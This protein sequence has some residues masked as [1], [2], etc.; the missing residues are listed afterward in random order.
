MTPTLADVRA[1]YD[2][3]LLD[4]VHRAATVHRA[5][6]DASEVQLCALQSIKTGGCGE[7]C[8]Y[9]AQSRHH[10]T[11]V[12]PE[13]LMDTE[14]VLAK[15]RAAKAAGSTRFCMGA[16]WRG[17]AGPRAFDRILD[18]VRGV[19]A[20][21]LEACMTLGQLTA[22]QARALA[23]AGLSAY[24]HNL[25]TSEAHY[26]KV[27]TTRTYADRLQT[28]GHVADAGISLCC[29]GILGL[30]EGADDRIALLHRLATLDP[31]PESVPINRLVPVPGT[32]LEGAAPLDVFAWVRCVAVARVLLPRSFVR[33][34]AGRE[35][36]SPEAQAL[37]FLAGANAIFV[38][39]ELLTTPN[40]GPEADAALLASLGLHGRAPD[41]QNH[42]A[43]A[44]KVPR[45]TE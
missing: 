45:L 20:L 36:L 3:P 24:N 37:A 34:S 5:H 38:G 8:G 16:A 18:M 12:T 1:L 33:L 35:S 19:R 15:A 41:G 13:P 7:D 27:I 14:A 6:W 29:G 28:I 32:P 26:A 31:Q 22:E 43:A 2:T 23:D 21:G 11:A 44:Q 42:P 9:C 30:G 25:D 40:A 39:E 4:L 10:K 17:P